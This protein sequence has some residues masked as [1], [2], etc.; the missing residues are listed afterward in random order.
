MA[1]K[2]VYAPS[3]EPFDVPEARANDLILQ[4]G[5]TQQA[6]VEEAV[7]EEEDSKPKRRRKQ[8]ETVVEPTEAEASEETSE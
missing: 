3:G 6:P 8:T 1:Y 4:K 7:V 5:W 2:R